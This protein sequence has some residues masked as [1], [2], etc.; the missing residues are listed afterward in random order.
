MPVYLIIE[1]TTKDVEKYNQYLEQVLPMIIKYG[2]YFHVRGEEIQSFGS[3][4]PERI[5]IIEFPSKTHVQKWQKSPE[6]NL[7]IPLRDAGAD[8][9]AILVNGYLGEN[10]YVR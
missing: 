2:G 6:Y 4:K 3:W 9:Q 10:G 8:T 7:I 5:I 1:S